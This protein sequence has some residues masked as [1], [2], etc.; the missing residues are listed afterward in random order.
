MYI[1]ICACTYIVY[2]CMYVSVYACMCAYVCLHVCLL[3]YTHKYI[4]TYIHTYIYIPTQG[5]TPPKAARARIAQ[6]QSSLQKQGASDGS[7][8]PG[9]GTSTSR[10]PRTSRFPP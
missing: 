7:A 1:C 5:L 4:H 9:Q 6:L 8:L 2:I 3:L 10:L